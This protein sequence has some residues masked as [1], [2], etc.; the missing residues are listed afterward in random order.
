MIFLS[1]L[2]KDLSTQF[3][4]D[5]IQ[6]PTVQKMEAFEDLPEPM[7]WTERAFTKTFQA[8]EVL[9]YDGEVLHDEEKLIIMKKNVKYLKTSSFLMATATTSLVISFVGVPSARSVELMKE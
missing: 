7:Q 9:N 4:H 8:L 2:Q 1:R 6:K 5:P 3:V